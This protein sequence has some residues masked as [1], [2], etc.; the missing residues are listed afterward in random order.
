MIRNAGGLLEQS[1]GQGGLPERKWDPHS[2]NCK[3]LDS[4][5]S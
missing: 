4:S 2:Y 1:E 5:N 3:Q